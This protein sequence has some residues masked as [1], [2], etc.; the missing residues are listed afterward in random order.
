MR[1]WRDYA[2]AGFVL[3]G[4]GALIATQL[5]APTDR[6]AVWFGAALGYVL[7]LAAFGALQ[8][9]R[10]N[11]QLFMLGWA[12][13]IGLRFLAVGIVAF[14]VTRTNVLPPKAALLSLVGFLML[15]LFLEPLFLRR[16]QATQ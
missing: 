8:A 2:V 14:W 11:A 4:L 7:Q 6:S 9:V 1:A 16:G 13:G 15:L 10:G 12:A 3:A 5:V